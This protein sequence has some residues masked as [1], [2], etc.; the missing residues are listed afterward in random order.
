METAGQVLTYNGSV[1]STLYSA[2]NGGMTSSNYYRWGSS[3]LPYFQVKLDE[4]DKEAS[5]QSSSYNTKFYLPK[6]GSDVQL[7]SYV[8]KTMLPEL[9]IQLYEQGY[10]A[11]ENNFEILGFD[12]LSLHTPRFTDQYCIMYLYLKADVTLKAYKGEQ[13][14]SPKPSDGADEYMQ[15]LNTGYSGRC[16]LYEGP[17]S[18]YS[19]LASPRE[20]SYVQ[21][22]SKS[23]S[24]YEVIAANG[25][26]GYINKSYLSNSGYT[27]KTAVKQDAEA[28]EIT[29]T[30][31]IPI[32]GLK[33]T[34][35]C[36]GGFSFSA[37][38]NKLVPY[39][40][41]QSDRWQLSINGNGHGIGL[42]QIGAAPRGSRGRLMRK[43][44]LFILTIQKSPLWIMKFWA[45]TPIPI[46]ILISGTELLRS[47]IPPAI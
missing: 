19:V 45:L 43:Y 10:S 16:S 42:S 32:E 46:W 28:E 20:G 18:Q 30:L 7:N 4:Y 17:G 8:Y 2:S 5:F 44:S 26:Y 35:T 31:N 1:I 47:A 13:G 41:E 12:N 23:G 29:L 21:I 11:D 24:Y 40:Q 33:Y 38:N 15:V 6:A 34:A 37:I 25:D 14:D 9:L 39:V 36:N 22:L 27:E 3:R